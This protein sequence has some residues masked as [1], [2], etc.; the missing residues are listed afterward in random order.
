M[1]I[2]LII[3]AVLSLVGGIVGIPESLGGHNAL[4]SWLEP[5][6]TPADNK[7]LIFPAGE[8]SA[9]EYILMIVS[10]GVATVGALVARNIFVKRREV[11]VQL[12]SRWNRFYRLLFNKYYVD[13]IYDAA[14]VNPV[15]NG[16]ERVLWARFDVGVIDAAV[17]GTAKL[18]A[19]GSQFIRRM[20]TG[21]VQGYALS[22]VIGI[23][24]VL[25]WLIFG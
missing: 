22:F 18:I 15:V 1:T 5:V 20:Q 23:I 14:I 17:N 21:V 8:V 11:A 13:E 12:A 6:F 24:F 16:S 19:I 4:G 25:G 9:A 7:L 10:L 2:P 3:L